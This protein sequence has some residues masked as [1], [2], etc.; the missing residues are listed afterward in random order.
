MFA[1]DLVG[2]VVLCC[3]GLGFHLYELFNYLYLK[4]LEFREEVKKAHF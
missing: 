2:V 3:R 1:I 4:D